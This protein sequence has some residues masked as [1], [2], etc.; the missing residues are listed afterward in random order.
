MYDPCLN[1][2]IEKKEK[3][4]LWRNE[5]EVQ[6]NFVIQLKVTELGLIFSFGNCSII[7]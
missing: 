3:E 2:G 1:P 6:M 5:R 7:M 4:Y